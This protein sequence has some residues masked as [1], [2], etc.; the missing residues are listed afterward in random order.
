MLLEETLEE[1]I[2]E[3]QL[4]KLS[5]RTVQSY[6]NANLRMLKYIKEQYGIV[7]LEKIHHLAVKGYIGFLTQQKLSE[8]Y[9]NRNIVCFRCFFQ[10]C[11]REG[12]IAENPMDKVSKQKEPVILIE[13]FTDEEVQRMIKVF[14]GSKFL[15]IRNALIMI[16]LF[17]SGLRNSEL[18]DLKVTDFRGTYIHVIGKGKKTRYLPVTPIIN[19][20]LIKYL[21]V[22]TE[23]IKDKLSYQTEYLFLSQKGKRLTPET[24]ERIVK[25]AGEEANIRKGIRISP[26]TCRHY[27]AQSQLKNGCDL[28]TVSKLLGHSKVETTRIYLQSMQD[29]DILEIAS[30]TSPLA[31]L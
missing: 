15:D 29:S 28:Y 7:E 25:L 16:M 21:R 19:K 12:Y 8:V 24:I 4:R 27:Y 26:H 14:T 23:Y 17:D 6:R 3:C 20:Y 22:R 13:T 9:I 1:F 2:F 31:N 10:Y 30:K 5:R 11:K 18:C